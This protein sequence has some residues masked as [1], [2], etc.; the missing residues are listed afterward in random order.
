M[1]TVNWVA[2][3]RFGTPLATESVKLT[4]IN[5]QNFHGLDS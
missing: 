1:S 3:S 5:K 2:T 4:F